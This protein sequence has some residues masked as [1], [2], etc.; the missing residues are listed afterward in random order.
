[1]EILRELVPTAARVE[2]L[3]NPSNTASTEIARKDLEP[4][5]RAMGL[6]IQILDASNSQEIN[7]A[8]ASFVRERPDALFVGLDPFLTS[9]RVQLATLATR[10]VVPM[11]SGTREIV[12]A[13]GLMSYGAS[14]RDALRQ[15]GVYAGRIVKGAKPSDLPVLRSSKFELVVNLQAARAIELEVPKA[16][17][18]LAD[19]VIDQRCLCCNALRSRLALGVF[20]G[21]QNSDAIGGTADIDWSP[22]PIA[23]EAYD[24]S[25][26]WS[27]HRSGRGW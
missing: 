19:E 12:E 20:R 13:G 9:R 2:V 11:T 1:M 24:P 21:A 5:A 22:A 23:Y 14:L 8:F 27:V 26:K 25:R 15:A 16:L 3:R 6:Q 17:Q 7:A 18:L 4:A 10:H